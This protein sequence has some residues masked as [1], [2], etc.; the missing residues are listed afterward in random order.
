MIQQEM[1]LVALI[2]VCFF[3]LLLSSFAVEANTISTVVC[4]PEIA[5]TPCYC[6]EY[7]PGVL[8]LDCFA[9]S[10]GDL[11]I[12][13]ILDTFLTNISTSSSL[14]ELLLDL[15]RLT[16]VPNQIKYLPQLTLVSLDFNLITSID[17][18]A[19]N[20]CSDAAINP[21]RYLGLASNQLATI[22]SD[23]FQGVNI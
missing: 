7:S 9:R 14:G 19:F 13:E 12:S 4:P 22:N 1:M 23:A 8:T 16:R 17:S 6:D 2:F 10:L 21:I 18:G 20:L 11:R 5:Y 3:T 15:N